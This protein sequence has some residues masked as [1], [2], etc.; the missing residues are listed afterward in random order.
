MNLKIPIMIEKENLKLRKIK[1]KRSNQI[2]NKVK[3]LKLIQ[4]MRKSQNIKRKQTLKS[5]R[6]WSLIK[7]KANK[8]QRI[9]R[10]L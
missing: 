6:K 1:R 5:S 8:K 3:N 10:V 9:K 2:Q 4:R 7:N